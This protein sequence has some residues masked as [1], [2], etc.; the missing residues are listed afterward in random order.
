VCSSDL[1]MSLAHA[2]FGPPYPMPR[3]PSQDEIFIAAVR[4][5]FPNLVSRQALP[6]EVPSQA[7]HLT[8]ASSSSQLAVAA[9][10]T[11]FEVRFYGDYLDDVAKG[12]AYV[13]RKLMAILRG[14]SALG[15][16]PSSIGLIA[17]FRFSFRGGDDDP[18]A[19]VLRTHLRTELASQD[20]Q[21]ALARVAVK[22]RDTY[23]VNLTVANYEARIFERPVLPGRM[24]II[25]KAWEARVDDTGLELTIDINNGLE[26]R[27]KGSD[28][29]VTEDGVKAVVR[30]LQEVALTAGPSFA[31][32]GIVSID[33]LTS[34]SAP[35]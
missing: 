21:D 19:H 33:S 24:Q 18:V 35:K 34:A 5:E 20:V 12:L 15:M 8:L 9:A 13:E 31:E 11:D 25:V 14:F 29:T 23:F 4:D 2:V 1:T 7:P 3:D 10:Q 16:T 22:V 26:G 32:T 28:P 6:P 30:L 17:S 27:T